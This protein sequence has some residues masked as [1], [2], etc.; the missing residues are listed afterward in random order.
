MRVQQPRTLSVG[1]TV[2]MSAISAAEVG[3]IADGID[4]YR[5][6]VGGL[7]EPLLGS[8]NEDLIAALHEAERALRNAHRAMR[9]ALKL[10]N[11]L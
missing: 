5:S 4:M 1:E 2:A 7:A 11:G 3:S 6:R 8:S 9:H 10:S